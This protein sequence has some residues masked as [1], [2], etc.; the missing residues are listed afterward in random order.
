MRLMRAAAFLQQSAIDPAGPDAGVIK[1]LGAFFLILLGIIFL[2]VVAL[3]VI[4]VFRRH[5]GIHQEPLEITHTPSLGTERKLGV[6]VTA[7]SAATLLI[8]FGLV[9]VSVSVGK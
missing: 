4:P 7:A 9:A 2:I 1:S 5:R 6:Y 8:L 3:A